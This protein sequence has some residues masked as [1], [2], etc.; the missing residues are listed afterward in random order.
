MSF[1]D[2]SPPD[3][4]KLSAIDA[5]AEQIH[6]R[7]EMTV[8]TFRALLSEAEAATNG[9]P[10]FCESLARYAPRSELT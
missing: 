10:E 6:A 3:W 9:H 4:N 8:E 5:R 2:S 1:D 7:G